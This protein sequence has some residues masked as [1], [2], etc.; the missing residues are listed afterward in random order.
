[1][2]R[3]DVPVIGRIKL[4]KLISVIGIPT[5]IF[6][7]QIYTAGTVNGAGLGFE[8]FISQEAIALFSVILFLLLIARDK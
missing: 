5:L 4:W 1:M 7:N 8:G 6:Y 2:P 3:I